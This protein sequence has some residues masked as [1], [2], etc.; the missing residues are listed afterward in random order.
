MP[1]R[2]AAEQASGSGQGAMM[3]N[4]GE[5]IEQLPLLRLG[6]ADSIGSH[7][8]QAQFS[9][10][11]Q[12]GLIASLFCAAKVALHFDIHVLCAKDFGEAANAFL[13]TFYSTVRKSMR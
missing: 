2:I 11:L 5:N 1:L 3:A 13:G 7:D 9:R 8:R 6:M 12:C 10:E 4:A